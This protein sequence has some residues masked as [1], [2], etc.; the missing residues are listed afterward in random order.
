ML[1]ERGLG[2]ALQSVADRAPVPVE[3]DVQLDDR[4]APAQEAALY[5]TAS[6]ALA[7]VAKYARGDVG[8][9]SAPGAR[10]AAS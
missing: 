8:V 4:L 9:R 5:F 6:E 2:P 7:N 3:L 1:T 10:T